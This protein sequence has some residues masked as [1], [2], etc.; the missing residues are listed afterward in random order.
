MRYIPNLPSDYR[1][2]VAWEKTSKRWRTSKFEGRRLLFYAEGED[3]DTVMR[4]TL[5]LGLQ[6]DDELMY[7]TKIRNHSGIC[8]IGG[9]PNAGQSCR[10]HTCPPQASEMTEGLA[11]S[12][13]VRLSNDLIMLTS[14]PALLGYQ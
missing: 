6:P 5:A 8:D 9:R 13:R 2:D 4:Q 14:V 11:A 10:Q 12:S 7:E 3:F 1:V